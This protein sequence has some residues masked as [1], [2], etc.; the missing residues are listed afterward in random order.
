MTGLFTYLI[1]KL[2]T[3]NTF[4]LS[5]MISQ[6]ISRMFGWSDLVINQL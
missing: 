1:H 4:V 6:I 5:Y 2:R 3:E